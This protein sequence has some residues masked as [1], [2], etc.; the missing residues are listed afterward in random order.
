MNN[1]K[2][3]YT[4]RRILYLLQQASEKAAKAYLFAYIKS[5]IELLVI[6]VGRV[7]KSKYSIISR[8]HEKLN[9]LNNRLEPKRIGHKSHKALIIIKIV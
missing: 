4:G 3:F 2:V 8:I 7:D 1:D 6:S 9:S 5:W